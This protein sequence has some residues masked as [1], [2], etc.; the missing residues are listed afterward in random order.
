MTIQRAFEFRRLLDL[1]AVLVAIAVGVLAIDSVL[2]FVL[3]PTP[4]FLQQREH[5][6]PDEFERIGDRLA[7]AEHALAADTTDR[8]LLMIL[9]L[10]TARVDID[11]EQLSRQLCETPRVLNLGSSGG[12]FRQLQFYL[13]TLRWTQLRP[14]MVVLGLHPAWIA[15]YTSPNAAPI[16]ISELSRSAEAGWGTLKPM[17]A[18][19]LW[20]G[21]NR[22]AVHNTLTYP[23]LRVRAAVADAFDLSSDEVFRPTNADPWSTPIDYPLPRATDSALTAQL[24]NWEKAGWFDSGRLGSN[25]AEVVALREIQALA[26]RIGTTTVVVL[27]P[28]SADFRRRTPADAETLLLRVLNE[29]GSPPAVV[30]LRASL[31]DSLLY[32]NAHVNL[33]GRETLTTLL[34]ARIRGT[35]H[36]GA[37]TIREDTRRLIRP[38]V[39]V[40]ERSR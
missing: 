5:L 22:A 32:D 3:G 28:E 33:R 13:G 35:S 12:S 11:A 29:D 27:M 39:P 20:A 6:S 17:L 7:T 15:G 4:R 26:Q 30:D 2:R 37:S 16:S 24:E 14:A 38:N 23:M 8:P 19:S 9:G 1:G 34:A 36:C 10:S 25:S 40:S 31:P 21:A 18:R